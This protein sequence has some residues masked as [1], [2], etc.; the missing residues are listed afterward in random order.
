MKILITGYKGFIGQNLFSHLQQKH[1]VYGYDWG[2]DAFSVKDYDWVIHLGAISSTTETN[3]EKIFNQNLKFTID[4]F[5]ECIRHGVNMQFASSASLYG[6]NSNFEESSILNPLTLYAWSKF[7]AEKYLLE[8]N[9]N[10]IIVQ[11]FRYFNVYGPNEKHKRNQAS[12]HSQFTEQAKTTGIIKLFKNSENYY[13][14][15]I[16]VN[17]VIKY[18]E[19]FLDINKSDV[20][21][22]GTGKATSFYSVAKQIQ[23]EYNCKI[24]F[25]DMPDNIKNSYQIYTKANLNK[26]HKTLKDEEILRKI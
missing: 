9:H 12:P 7:L 1:K 3:F 26:L 21:N 20:W 2:D 22:I 15:F 19:L 10:D 24:E 17:D 6:K 23:K 13:R 8:H 5:N 18:H 11:I 14:D 4:L 16:H 25:I